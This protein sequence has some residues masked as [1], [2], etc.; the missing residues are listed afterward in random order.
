MKDFQIFGY[1]QELVHAGLY[2]FYVG[3]FVW[4]IY[5]WQF[6]DVPGTS[7][8]RFTFYFL[9]KVASGVLLTL[10]YTYY[11]TDQQK[12]DIYRY[13]NDSRVISPLLFSNPSAWFSIMTGVGI[14]DPSV[15]QYLVHTHYFSHPGHDIVTNNT[16]IIRV[17]VLINYLSVSNIYINTLLINWISFLSLTLLYK[18][19][20]P[21]FSSFETLLQLP[22]FLLPSVVF[23]SSGLLKEALLFAC[24]GPVLHPFVSQEKIELKHWLSG[25]IAALLVL[26]IKLQVGVIM[27]LGLLVLI[28]FKQK[29]ISILVRVV[30]MTM[31]VL[32][33]LVLWGDR[34]AQLL[35]GKRN[36]FAE[37]ARLENAGSYLKITIYN[38]TLNNVV[39]LL[40]EAF[41]NSIL[42]PYIWE[43]GKPFQL[44]FAAE[45]TLFLLL[46]AGLLFFYKKPVGF[47]LQLCLC[48]LFIAIA[49][50]MVIGITV[51]V[52]G[53]IVHYRVIAAPFLLL[54][55][56]LAVDLEKLRKALPSHF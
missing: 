54:G 53:A 24:M 43:G 37:L 27:L 7:R 32:G 44:A 22:L 4:F 46:L 19:L 6:F 42:R 26:Y 13:F 8:Q 28:A 40:P 36:E 23:W 25:I 55:V 38:P 29:G 51:P 56:L 18:T 5:K 30:A 34:I 14:E 41:Q 10:I 3:L 20:R 1:M 31:I 33:V 48:F 2:V 12:A 15:F 11:Y 17:N 47:R 52:L 39:R 49:N 35:I 45:N 50:Y 9:L 16:F 21:Y